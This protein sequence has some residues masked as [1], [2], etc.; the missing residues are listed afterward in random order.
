MYLEEI[1][2]GDLEKDLNYDN[3]QSMTYLEQ[4]ICETLR[5]H[6]P[7]GVL[8]R[9]TTKDYLVPGSDLIFPKDHNVWINVMAIHFDPK[10]YSDPHI[11][12]PDHFS[13]EAKSK[14]SL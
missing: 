10:H 6:N 3:L 14:R 5:F 11:F 4:V 8:R 1:T 9:S 13:K 12:N 2:D 7:I